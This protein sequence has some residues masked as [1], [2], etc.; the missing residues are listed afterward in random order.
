[1]VSYC[2]GKLGEEAS[3]PCQTISEVR[4]EAAPPS[5]ITPLVTAQEAWPARGCWRPWLLLHPPPV[6]LAQLRPAPPQPPHA[7]AEPPPRV[8]VW[9]VL[10]LGRG[11]SVQEPP[12][13]DITSTL[14]SDPFPPEII[15]ARRS[16]INMKTWLLECVINHL[17]LSLSTQ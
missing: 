6:S 9:L 3:S 7:R 16:K 11:G 13:G 4:G 1:M 8:S 15:M 2:R 14:V 17:D 12:D 10:G 5:R